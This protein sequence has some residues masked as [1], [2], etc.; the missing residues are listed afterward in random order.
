MDPRA[1]ST[2]VPRSTQTTCRHTKWNQSQTGR[3]GESDSFTSLSPEFPSSTSVLLTAKIS[4]SELLISLS[5]DEYKLLLLCSAFNF[6]SRPWCPSM[7]SWCPNLDVSSFLDTSLSHVF[8]S[9]SPFQVVDGREGLWADGGRLFWI[10]SAFAYTGS[11]VFEYT[12][13]ADTEAFE[14]DE[15][16]EEE[17]DTEIFWACFCSK[18]TDEATDG[19]RDLMES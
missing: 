10:F 14:E 11:A 8:L 4:S 7:W 16:E 18:W 12:G 1:H 5:D 19:C 15:D 17:E 9:S 6:P 2:S 3:D 13:W